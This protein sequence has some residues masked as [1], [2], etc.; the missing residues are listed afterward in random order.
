MERR[1]EIRQIV[2]SLGPATRA[3]VS[4]IVATRDRDDTVVTT[5]RSVLAN[6]YPNFELIIVDQSR[7]DATR[8]ALEPFVGDHRCRYCRTSSTGLQVARNLGTREARHEIVITTDDDC[9]VP[10]DWVEEFANVFATDNRISVVFGRVVPSP[11]DDKAGFIPSYQFRDRFVAS[12]VF[13]RHRVE[14]MGACFGFRR[15]AWS[16]LNGFDAMLGVGSPFQSAG[17]TDFALRALEVGYRV[18][19]SPQVHVLHHGFRT[20]QEGDALLRRYLFGVGATYAKHLRHGHWVVLGDL[21]AVGWRFLSGGRAVDTGRQGRGALKLG[22]FLRGAATGLTAP[23][24]SETRNFV[25]PRR[26]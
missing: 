22:A 6:E 10:P 4:V 16:S 23:V 18:C 5:V 1:P 9:E 20:W 17:E 7:D 26:S 13:E 14:G 21:L 25:E 2:G 19:K 12:R 15:G 8:V 24:N 3:P 11:H